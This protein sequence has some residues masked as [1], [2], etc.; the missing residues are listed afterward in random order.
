MKKRVIG[1]GGIFFKCKDPDST[2]EWYGKHL[3]LVT[4]PYG[5][6]FEFRN[7]ENPEEKNFLQWSTFKES[8]HYMAPSNAD[9]MVNY[10]V[11]DLES[12][13]KVLEEEGVEVVD[14]I[15]NHDYGKFVHIMDPEGNKVELWE[16]VNEV[17]EK[18]GGGLTTK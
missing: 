2:R 12:L 4:N 18:M 11:E 3:G 9:F 5:S 7:A 15:A 13:V 6:T 1:I 10:R 17:Y 14:E 16:A 8:T